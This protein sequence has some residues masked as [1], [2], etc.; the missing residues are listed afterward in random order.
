[1]NDVSIVAVATLTIADTGRPIVL[2]TKYILLQR[3][4][5]LRIGS[6]TQ[7]H[8]SPLEIILYGRSDDPHVHP[9]FG[10]KFIGV[11]STASI[12]IHGP[13]KLSWTFLATTLQPGI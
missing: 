5:G 3:N 4:G 1:M 8:T 6:E 13:W 11:D 12:D 10:R 7:P 2:R 9:V